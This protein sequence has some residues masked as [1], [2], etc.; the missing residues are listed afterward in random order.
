MSEQA[1]DE[2]DPLAALIGGWFGVFESVL[3]P[4]AFVATYVVS[5]DK[6]EWAVAAGIGIGLVLAAARVMRGERPVRVLGA[7]LVVIAAAL[8]AYYTGDPA[9]YFWPLV[10]AN[11]ASALV[12]AFSILIR[13]PLMGVIVGPLVGIGMSWRRDP[14]LMRAWQLATWPWVVLNIVRAL[15]QIPLIHGEDLWA[16]AA[17]RPLFVGLVVLTIASSWAIIRRVLPADH[18]GIRHPRIARA[19]ATDADLG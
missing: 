19:N 12:F 13:W 18:P 2:R 7:L 1:S 8:V 9:A 4:L 10:L 15:V 16:L 5:G 11:A 14:D 6:L 3:P 17:I